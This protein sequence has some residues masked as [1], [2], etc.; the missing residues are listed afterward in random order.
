MFV[1][2]TCPTWPGQG[3][4]S[5]AEDAQAKPS[6]FLLQLLTERSAKPTHAHQARG[7]EWHCHSQIGPAVRWGINSTTS[8]SR[9]CRQMEFPAAH[10]AEPLHQL[11]RVLMGQSIRGVAQLREAGDK[12]GPGFSAIAVFIRGF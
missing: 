10:F 3:R 4:F 12:L 8:H 9:L 1:Q 6:C 5:L 11:S 2:P 7:G